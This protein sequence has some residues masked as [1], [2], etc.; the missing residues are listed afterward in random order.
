MD[1]NLSYQQNL[2]GC[3]ILLIV[4]RAPNNRYESLKPLIPTVLEKIQ[5]SGAT[6]G[7]MIVVGT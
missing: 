3:D 7:S 4:L 5:E 6:S 2:A 1:S